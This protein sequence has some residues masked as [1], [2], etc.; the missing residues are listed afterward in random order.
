MVCVAWPYANG[1]RHIGHVA[2]FG[3]PSDV[4]ARY[5]RMA[6]NEVLMVSGTD[7]FG[8]PITVQAD[9]EDISPQ[10][11]VDRYQ[12]VISQD[13]FKLG[14][15]YDLFTRTTTDNH[16][17]QVQDFFRVLHKKGFLIRQT[18]VG[19]FSKATGATLPDRYIEGTCPHCK[20]KNARGDQCDNCG[21][22]LDPEE[23][24]EPRSRIDGQAPIFKDSEH[25]FLDLP[26][27]AEQLKQWLTEKSHWRA[28]VREFSL[29]IIKQLKPRAITRDMSWGIPIPLP[30]YENR[31]DK[32]IYVWFD[33]VIG[34]F[35]ASVEWAQR[36]GNPDGWKDWWQDSK[37]EH[38][39]F[40]G[41]DNVV[42]HSLIW[43]TMLMGFGNG[44]PST[45]GGEK[46]SPLQT[47]T[48][49]FSSEFLTMEGKKFSSSRGVVIYVR[50]FLERY[51]PDTLRFFISIAGP[52]NQDTD[53]T[54][55]EFVRRNNDEL[56]ACWG[57]LV[58]RVLSMAHQH[59][60][61]I[62]EPPPLGLKEENLI[63]TI[64]GGFDTVGTM[65]EKGSL[66]AAINEVLRLANEVN[67]YLNQREPWS[68]LKIPSSEPEAKA[69]I[70]AAL[71]AINNLKLMMSPF[72]PFSCQQLHQML[73]YQDFLQGEARMETVTQGTRSWQ[74]ITGDY[75][76]AKFRW[77]PCLLPKGIPLASPK[78]LFQK[79]ESSIIQ[80]ELDRLSQHCQK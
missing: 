35:S 42:F 19:A 59:Y 17:R 69:V 66:K 70:Y 1:P 53:F 43:P 47:P 48:N 25:F 61:A 55:A 8:T 2:G 52:E 73:G 58:H 29:G 34:Y 62:P 36:N 49:I 18:T 13:L 72:L 16:R 22:Q 67:R 60:N 68:L 30:E 44:L 4:F 9:E 24:I 76:A 26:T 71:S 12:E 11:L 40:M 6:G 14:I 39:Y 31:N 20:D 41:K 15:N 46:G 23:L 63:N 54:W 74:I 32:R 21:N 5:Q 64:N 65:I 57:N 56:V 79:L 78:P 51:H 75:R 3:V 27:F 38:F 33:A 50:D 80:E 37:T 10:Q 28:N 77:K 7:E 45:I